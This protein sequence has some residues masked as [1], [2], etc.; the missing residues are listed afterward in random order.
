MKKLIMTL[1]LVFTFSGTVFAEFPKY[2]YDNPDNVFIGEVN[3]VAIYVI[4]SRAIDPLESDKFKHLLKY[5]MLGGNC[6]WVKFNEKNSNVKT[7][8]EVI[9]GLFYYENNSGKKK[10]YADNIRKGH[11]LNPNSQNEID[12][13][14]MLFGEALYQIKR[15]KPFYETIKIPYEL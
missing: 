11:Y 2:L 5:D 3:G 8:V 14:L 10:M 6:F 15:N 13:I 12:K 7:K 9:P 4:K 1:L